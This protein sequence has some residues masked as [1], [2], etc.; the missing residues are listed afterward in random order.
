MNKNLFPIY[1][2][3]KGRWENP[4]TVSHLEKMKADYRVIVEKQEWKKYARSIDKKRLLV[5]DKSFQEK[6]DTCDDLGGKI[7]KGSG[8]ARNFGWEHSIDRGF[9]H[10]WMMDDN[11]YGFIRFENNHFYRVRTTTF[12]RIMEDFILRYKNVGMAGPNYDMFIHPWANNSPVYINSRIFSCNLIKNDMPHRWRGRWNE[13]A[14]LSF[15]ILKNGYCTVL[16]NT[17]LQKKVATQAMKG[18]NT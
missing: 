3:S 18:G 7:S 11:I 16:F 2:P 8:A 17:F 13:D 1:I 4:V 6:Y 9:D 14:I 10:H 5:L 15:D 12:F